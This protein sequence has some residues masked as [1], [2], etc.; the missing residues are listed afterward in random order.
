LAWIE[1]VV[2]NTITDGRRDKYYILQV[3]KE[4][5]ARM[6]CREIKRLGINFNFKHP[7]WK[8]CRFQTQAHVAI[9]KTPL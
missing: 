9:L 4:N 5:F 1:I 6:T 8:F 2:G 3:V 7:F